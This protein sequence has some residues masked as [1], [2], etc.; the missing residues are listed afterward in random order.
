[1]G[2]TPHL[3]P[4]GSGLLPKDEG[5]TSLAQPPSRRSPVSEHVI[6]LRTED[7]LQTGILHAAHEVVVGVGVFEDVADA[8]M[9][10]HCQKTKRNPWMA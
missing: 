8:S 4:I 5:P 2:R 10:H 7:T 6:R 9:L 3:V 1:M